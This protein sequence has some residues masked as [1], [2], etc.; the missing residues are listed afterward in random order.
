MQATL[1]LQKQI[2]N[3]CSIHA[4]RLEAL[5]AAVN[6]LLNCSKLTV[7]N[8]GRGIANNTLDKHNINRMNRLIGNA[9]LHNDRV[10]LY[11]YLARCVLG[12]KKRPIISVDWC[13]IT[14]GGRD[15]L[16]RATVSAKGRPL[17]I[18]E[19]MYT[20][21]TYN[22]PTAHKKF[23]SELAS[24]LPK[25]CKPTIVTDAGFGKTW[26]ELV[27]EKGWDYLG[28]IRSNN[29]FRLKKE[30]IYKS[31][32]GLYKKATAKARFIGEVLY[33]KADFSCYFHLVKKA[34]VGRKL[35]NYMGKSSK[36]TNSLRCARMMRD[37]WLLVTSLS[38]K[39]CNS[40][41]TMKIYESR[42]QIEESFRDLKNTRNG[43]SLKSSRTRC[44]KR[45]DILVL[46]AHVATYVIWMIGLASKEKK[47]HYSLQTNSIK[48]QDVLSIFTIGLLSFN[49]FKF[50]KD[51]L[52]KSKSQI[53]GL[54]WDFA[55][56]N[57]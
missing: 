30:T 12:T 3:S 40:I 54:I 5:F 41:K 56:G 38:N 42:M 37:P 45:F 24:V 6:A 10:A 18:Y 32:L 57:L 47:L 39:E 19:S 26:F 27:L 29:T 50:Y 25:D 51:E 31:C 35:T 11:S 46:I 1:L 4:T 36:R 48:N 2:Q 20:H 16:I 9:K 43:F 52:L 21:K 23:L 8:L 22:N 53:N 34:S 33:T 49:R 13:A 15:Q 14:P 28:R 17:V 44:V 7:V 55:E